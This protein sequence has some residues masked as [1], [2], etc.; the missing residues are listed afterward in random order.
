MATD[1]LGCDFG[2]DVA[3]DSIQIDGDGLCL[4]LPNSLPALQAWFKH[5]PQ[6]SS[7]AVEATGTFHLPL[8]TLAQR[9][10]HT[11]YLIDGFRL[12]RYRES[13][14]GRAKTDRLDAQLLRRYLQHERARLHPWCAP[15]AGYNKVLSLL[16]CRERLVTARVMLEQSFKGLP[17]SEHDAKEI[18]RRMRGLELTMQK[19]IEACA[20]Q[21]WV[22]HVKRCLQI[23]GV[24]PLTAVAL[25]TL[26]HRGVFLNSDAF[27]AFIGL[28]VQARDSGTQRGRRK[29]SKKGNAQVRRLLYNAAMA[30]ARSTTWRPFYQRHLDRGLSKTQALVALARKLA[31]VAF[32]LMKNECDYQPR[33]VSMPCTST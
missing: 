14:G 28:D 8:V 26:Y 21:Y 17:E 13:I 12:S 24:G 30:A 6:R 33:G 11:V 3:K 19:R 1:Q 4:E 20:R 7:F 32:A 31:R 22:E 18:T 5:V 25:A 29:L 10:G 27:I 15:P 16:S 23:E 2:V 9:L